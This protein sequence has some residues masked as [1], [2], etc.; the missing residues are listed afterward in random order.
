MT[1][2]IGQKYL[3]DYSLTIEQIDSK[4]ENNWRITDLVP[5]IKG[6]DYQ[7][8]LTVE[9]G[10]LRLRMDAKLDDRTKDI[11]EE[12]LGKAVISKEVILSNPT[13]YIG[14]IVEYKGYSNETNDIEWRLFGVDAQGNLMLKANDYVDLSYKQ[15]DTAVVKL[16]DNNYNI[17]GISNRE[18]LVQYLSDKNNWKEY[19]V[20]GK[21]I[22]RAAMTRFE[23]AECYNLVNE[24]KIGDT[25]YTSTMV[26]E[27]NGMKYYIKSS[28]KAY[29]IWLASNHNTYLDFTDRIDF[30]GIV[31]SINFNHTYLGICPII[32]IT[33]TS[34]IANQDGSLIVE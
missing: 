11:I 26:E 30:L 34:I 8:I 23:F 28:E 19:S 32:S 12:K 29:S 5:S 3:T 2:Q 15:L 14:S 10:K 31:G 17:A 1:I 33:N 16:G 18:E 21:T 25:G 22:S 13:K 7:N 27:Y 9:N 20:E 6:T 4:D 24:Q